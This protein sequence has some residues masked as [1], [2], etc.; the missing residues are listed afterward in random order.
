[1]RE[2]HYVQNDPL[3][4]RNKILNKLK[5]KVFEKEKIKEKAEMLMKMM[6]PKK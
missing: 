4:R 1:M 5:D 6:F 2:K 3:E